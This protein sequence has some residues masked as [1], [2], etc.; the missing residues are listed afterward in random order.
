[1]T[2]STTVQ[3]H[4][5]VV[6]DELIRGEMTLQQATTA[7]QERYIQAV[8]SLHGG[9]LTRSA[10]FLGV[11]RNTVRKHLRRSINGHTAAAEG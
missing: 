7:F 5:E 2:E 10:R 9:N 1:M 11:H 3:H 4:L 6:L 8:V